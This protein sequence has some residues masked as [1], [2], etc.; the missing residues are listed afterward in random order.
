MIFCKGW[1]LEQ[2]LHKWK[3]WCEGFEEPT[4]ELL[5]ILGAFDWAALLNA[6]LRY[7]LTAVLRAPSILFMD[8]NEMLL[9][10]G[11]IIE[12]LEVNSQLLLLLIWLLIYPHRNSLRQNGCRISST[13]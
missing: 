5:R 9:Q 8:L 6:H 11:T 4:E 1:F 10:I 2:I 3:Y 12:W 7:V 13:D